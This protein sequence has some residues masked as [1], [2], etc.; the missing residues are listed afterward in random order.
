MQLMMWH[1]LWKTYGKA[2]LIVPTIIFN[3]VCQEMII[4]N[5]WYLRL[6]FSVLLLHEK[7]DSLH[8]VGAMH[9]AHWMSKVIYSLRIW[10][11]NAQFKLTRAQERG[12]RDV[13]VR[14][15]CI[16]ESLDLCTSGSLQ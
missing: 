13:C 6:C 11:F 15:K 5:S 4:K 10:M 1:F 12:L 9:H 16:P 14:S 7:C 3:R 2:P 8:L